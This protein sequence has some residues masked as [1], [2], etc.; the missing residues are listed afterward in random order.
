MCFLAVFALL[1]D[2]AEEVAPP[3][4]PTVDLELGVDTRAEARDDRL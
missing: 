3:T 2:V 4:A 1:E